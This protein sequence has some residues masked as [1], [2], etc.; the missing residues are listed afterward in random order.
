MNNI[1][2][3]TL[4]KPEIGPV[5]LLAGLLLLLASSIN[6]TELQCDLIEDSQINP[7]I[8]VSMLE[9]AD[10]GNLYR[11]DIT[12]SHIT[13]NVKH[14]PF[15]KLEGSFN[16]FDGGLTMPADNSQTRQ[17]LFLVK[18]DSMDTGNRELDNYLKSTVFF[19]ASKFPNIIFVSTGFEWINET[20]AKLYG[21]LTLRGTTKPL[22]FNV[23]IDTK[24]SYR[25]DEEQ[26]VIIKASAEIHRSE[27]GMHEL[28]L[29]VSDTVRFNFKIE[30]SRVGS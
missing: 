24:D 22:V 29:L 13:F 23:N 26:S 27:F 12:T 19:D 9:A 3:H 20:T 25:A 7:D 5:Y 10:K 16:E 28:S 14:F 6:A 4:G 1:F 17:A 15:S 11:V 2:S 8:I 21:E 30:A 18:V